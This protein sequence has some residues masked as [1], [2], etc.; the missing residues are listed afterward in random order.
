MLLDALSTQFAQ[1]SCDGPHHLS[2]EHQLNS[3]TPCAHQITKTPSFRL[4]HLSVEEG[5]VTSQ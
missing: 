5:R 2:I 4:Q 1:L 3:P